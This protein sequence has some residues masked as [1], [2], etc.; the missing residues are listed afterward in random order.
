MWMNKPGTGIKQFDTKTCFVAP[1]REVF[2]TYPDGWVGG[3][4]VVGWSEFE[5]S[6]R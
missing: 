5:F 2:T 3:E 1:N 6:D 4:W